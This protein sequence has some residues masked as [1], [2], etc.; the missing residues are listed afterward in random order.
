MN[1]MLIAQWPWWYLLLVVYC[2]YLGID[3]VRCYWR[4]RP[5][6]RTAAAQASTPHERGRVAGYRARLLMPAIGWPMAALGLL[7]GPLWIRCGVAVAF[8]ASAR[9]SFRDFAVG[10]AEGRKAVE[11]AASPE[12]VRG[13]ARPA[14]A[15]LAAA[16]VYVAL[17][18]GVP[19]VALVYS[20]W[21]R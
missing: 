1:S 12:Y 13:R 11:L 5:A 6:L 7:W 10:F 9:S 16:A 18:H 3:P 2:F 17:R 21:I 15:A 4:S 19:L 14:R 20:I 8:V